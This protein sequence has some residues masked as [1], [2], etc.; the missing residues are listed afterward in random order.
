MKNLLFLLFALLLFAAC[1]TTTT[2]EAEAEAEE[3]I[4]N[5]IADSLTADLTAFYERGHINGFAVAVVNEDKVLYQNGF[6]FSDVHAKAAYTDNTVQNI[7]SISKTLIGIALVKAQ[8][9]GKLKLDDPINDYLPYAVVNPNFPEDPITIRHLTTHTSSIID[10]EV[11]DGQS[12]IISD[13]QHPSEGRNQGSVEY[14]KPHSED[15]PMAT[16]L[17]NVLDEN[18]EWYSKDIF[19]DKRPGTFFDYTNIGATLAAQVLEYATGE[20]F[21]DF[22]TQ[23]ILTPLGMKSSGWSFDAIDFAQHSTMYADSI[24][25]LPFYSL[26]TYPDGGLRTSSADFGLYLQELIRGYAG[27]GII[28]T[29]EGYE[30]FYEQQM[31]DSQFEERDAEWTYNDEYDMGVFIGFAAETYI[32]HTGGDPGVSSFMFFDKDK[33]IGRFLMV[34]TNINNEEGWNEF[35]GIWEKM[36]EYEDRL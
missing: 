28:L 11:Y 26:V 27:N 29:K 30:M 15:L 17:Q 16:F 7:A 36:K 1:T 34:N 22:T 31:N 10:T 9:M 14:F 6:G 19:L 3:E 5:P 12:Y 4:V 35:F 21:A 2:P 25:E 20:N 33:K 13:R 18:G 8:E 23:H 32:G 24:T